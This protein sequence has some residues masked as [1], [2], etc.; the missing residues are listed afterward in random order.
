MT[1]TLG[2]TERRLL[3]RRR[4]A[5][6]TAA[7]PEPPPVAVPTCRVTIVDPNAMAG[8][9]AAAAWLA[10]A[11]GEAEAAVALRVLAAAVHAQRVATGDPSL[12]EPSRAQALVCRVGYGLGEQVAEGRWVAA[13]TLPAPPTSGKGRTRVL[14]PQERFGALLS[15]RDV[16]LAAETLALDARREWDAGRVREAALALRIALEAALAEL[17]PWTE[18]GDLAE[19]LPALRAQRDAVADAANAALQGG[20]GDEQVAAVGEALRLVEAAL[21]TRAAAA[22]GLL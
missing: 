9:D 1:T 18:H 13:Q 17:V 5:R 20:L 19:R 6:P 2:A 15:G 10:S 3:P 12:R 14:G 8:R 4:K 7:A 11:D 21:R 22:A 16:A